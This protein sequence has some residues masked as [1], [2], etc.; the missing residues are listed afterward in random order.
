MDSRYNKQQRILK[1]RLHLIPEVKVTEMHN[2]RLAEDSKAANTKRL[3]VAKGT[4]D[5]PAPRA[6]HIP[7]AGIGALHQV[8]LLESPLLLE[9][10]EGH[11]L[12]EACSHGEAIIPESLIIIIF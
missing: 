12:R 11:P 2:V 5:F 3:C 1:N 8:L 7:E 4:G 10:D 9:R 6:L